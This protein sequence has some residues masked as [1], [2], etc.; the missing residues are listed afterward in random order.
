MAPA[1]PQSAYHLF[2]RFYKN[3]TLDPRLQMN[4]KYGNSMNRV[5]YKRYVQTVLNA[6]LDDKPL[7]KKSAH[8]K[9]I[10]NDSFVGMSQEVSKKWKQVDALTRSI[11]TELANEDRERYKKVSQNT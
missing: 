1:T 2:F 6:N 7:D 10:G 8:P 5:G 11:F 9:F 3:V 4:S